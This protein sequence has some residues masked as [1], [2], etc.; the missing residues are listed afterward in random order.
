MRYANSNLYQIKQERPN[1]TPI[2]LKED[3][4]IKIERPLSQNTFKLKKSTA[5]RLASSNKWKSKYM[6]NENNSQTSSFDRVCVA[7]QS[8]SKPMSKT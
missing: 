6:K 4:K 7:N 5:T 1:T 2:Q 8:I 3:T